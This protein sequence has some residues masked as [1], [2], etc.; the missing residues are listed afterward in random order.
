MAA[1]LR[2]LWGPST[3]HAAIATLSMLALTGRGYP[4]PAI[5]RNRAVV[6]GRVRYIARDV[7]SSAL[8]CIRCSVRRLRTVLIS[9][10]TELLNT[11]NTH[12][13]EA[14]HLVGDIE[15]EADDAGTI[16]ALAASLDEAG[17]ML[18]ALLGKRMSRHG[19]RPR[20]NASSTS[21]M[22]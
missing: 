4:P 2:V 1:R 9:V 11:L 15:H 5:E 10:D 22:L 20:R 3:R 16:N 17:R 18:E 14:G 8:D 7:E 19:G 12:V 6:M 21:R 13:T